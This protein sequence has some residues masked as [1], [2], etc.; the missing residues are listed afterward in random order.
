MAVPCS[1]IESKAKATIAIGWQDTIS[2]TEAEG[3]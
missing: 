3:L 1:R 2:A